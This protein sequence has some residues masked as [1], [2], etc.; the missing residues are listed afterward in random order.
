VRLLED[1]VKALTGQVEK[2]VWGHPVVFRGHPIKN[3][4]HAS[5][6]PRRDTSQLSQQQQQE[7][8]ER[9]RPRRKNSKRQRQT[10][11]KTSKLTRM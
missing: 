4:T 5:G 9:T 8:A 6:K 2:P 10:T 3:M 7:R 1:W 11:R